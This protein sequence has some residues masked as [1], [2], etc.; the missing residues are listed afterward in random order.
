[1][2]GSELDHQGTV[3]YYLSVY[4][5]YCRYNNQFNLYSSSDVASIHSPYICLAIDN[6]IGQVPHCHSRS[7]KLPIS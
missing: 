4:I 5:T 7:I 2:R 3:G 6:P 1:V